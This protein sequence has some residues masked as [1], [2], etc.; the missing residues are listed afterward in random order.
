MPH[1]LVRN[2]GFLRGSEKQR[3]LQIQ[4]K[5]KVWDPRNKQPQPPKVKD[6]NAMAKKQKEAEFEFNSDGA[7]NE[8][9]RM[10]E[11]FGNLTLGRES[12]TGI[13]IGPRKS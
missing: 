13:I 10:A 1:K 2:L 6:I 9:I 11:G 4:A 7:L 3:I 5:R 12:T 8:V